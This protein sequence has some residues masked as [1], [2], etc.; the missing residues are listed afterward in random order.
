MEKV[1][2]VGS[3][4]GGAT[5]AKNLAKKGMDVTIIEKGNWV[6]ASKAYQCYDN[7]DVGVELLKATCVGG[8]TLVT[9]GNA[10]RTCQKEFKNIGINIDQELLE[11]ERELNVN[12]LPDSHMGEGTKKI[13]EAA[14]DLGLGMEKMPKFI[15]PLKCIP[16]GQCV[17]GCP[18]NA[19][20]STLSYLEEAENSGVNILSNTSVEKIITKKGAV[21]GVKT[22]EKEYYPD[23]V[24]LSA[25][26]IETPRILIR[27]GLNAGEQLFVDTFITVGGIFKGIK[28]N[29]EVSTNS[30]WKGN[31]FILT[32][33]YT[34]TTVEMLKTTGYGANDILGM[35]VMIKDDTSGRVTET[36]VVKDNTAHDV[37]LLTEGSAIAGAILETAG[38]DT[39]TIVSTPARGA[40]PGGT[41]A[42]RDVVDTNLETEINGLYVADASVFPSSPG[43]PPVL[44]I[45]ALAKRL[46]KYLSQT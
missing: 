36:G 35:M 7:M 29:K 32:P 19:K 9:A 39:S 43:S 18:R 24:V 4:A 46:A 34:S 6:N 25:G 10:V 38:V 37:G 2:V 16:C 23:R 13:V 17:L 14:S 30:L 1:L 15:D 33:H 28:F 26:A 40:H 5:V 27:S 45:M 8:T 21:Q 41:A 44:T 31:D 42:I 11:V 20:W 12:T 3:G 22:D